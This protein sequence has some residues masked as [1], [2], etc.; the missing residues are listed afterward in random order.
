MFMHYFSNKKYILFFIITSLFCFSSVKSSV[1]IPNRELL[2][3]LET[4]DQENIERTLN[5]SSDYNSIESNPPVGIGAM[6]ITTILAL[7]Q[8][9]APLLVSK[10]IIK[11]IIDHKNVFKDFSEL[12][13]M[14]LCARYSKFKRFGI[15][16]SIQSF[17]KNCSYINKCRSLL[18]VEL[19]KIL[20]K[21]NIDQINIDLDT[22]SNNK[23]FQKKSAPKSLLAVPGKDSLCYFEMIIYTLANATPLNTKNYI[24][25]RV[26][27]ELY[28]II[29]INYYK[30]RSKKDLA[31]N[32]ELKNKLAAT[33]IE[34]EIGLRVNH[35]KDIEDLETDTNIRASD[36]SLKVKQ[37][38]EIKF[39]DRLTKL[40]V[41]KNPNN[42]WAIYASGHGLPEL[43][44]K[45]IISQL[46]KLE[47]L[48]QKKL[49]SKNSLTTQKRNTNFVRSSSRLKSVKKEIDKLKN[50]L[51]SLK[52]IQKGI[53]VSL[54]KEDFRDMLKF[55][56]DSINTG[57]LFYTSCFAGGN[58][59]IEPYTENNK[60]IIFNY[61]IV[62]GTLAE[63]MSMQEMPGL[64]LPPYFNDLQVNTN[65][66]S[67]YTLTSNDVDLKN[68]WL[69][70][71]TTLNFEEFFKGLRSGMHQDKKNFSKLISILHPYCATNNQSK[72][73]F[74]CNIPLIRFTGAQYFEILP[75]DD[76]FVA[77]TKDFLG[78]NRSNINLTEKPALL[79][80]DYVDTKISIKKPKDKNPFFACISM[81]PGL[82][83]HTFKAISA[84]ALDLIDVANCFLT[85][86]ELSASKIFWIKDLSCGNS[87]V[88]SKKT[89]LQDVIIVRNLVNANRLTNDIKMPMDT[90]VY[91]SDVKTKRS[92][93]I[94]WNGPYIEVNNLTLENCPNN[95]YKNELM[96]YCPTIKRHLNEKI[97]IA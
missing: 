42:I 34:N 93:K 76:S 94:T 79:F 88:D 90:C 12:S 95:N 40:F 92:Y 59:L 9:V 24:F 35:L 4:L 54:T 8:K 73:D 83:S 41:L 38:K 26:S 37:P 55:F 68:R 65:L 39:K 18:D 44:T 32:K 2:V 15:S 78:K 19:N 64:K 85:F 5:S 23:L 10:A 20:K 61:P 6:T 21:D 36:K 52:A 50:Q 43:P 56:N 31:Y 57:F 27:K 14:Q 11:N 77:V 16:C 70:I 1:K 3:L 81:I 97:A 13:L 49:D 51:K 17:K 58:H 60:P 29:P 87:P 91:F 84:P 48:Y 45:A 75:Y 46:E 69:K 30:N 33:P 28:L 62:S 25:K 47:N 96:A 66:P 86:P 80:T 71:D 74:I 22:L 7:H 89:K 63:N 82:A 72:S 67:K 53:I